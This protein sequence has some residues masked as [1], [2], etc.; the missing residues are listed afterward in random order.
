M[1]Q[2]QTVN[3]LNGIDLSVLQETILAVKE[4]PELGK[5][6]LRATNKW[7]GGTHNRTTIGDFFAAGE[8][9]THKQPFEVE[10]DEPPLLAGDDEAPNPVEYLLSSLASCVTTSLVAHA[11]VR[12]IHIEELESEVEGDIDVRGCLGLSN[13]VPRGYT[14]IR[15]TCHVKADEDNMD[16]L[17]RLAQ[18]SPVYSTLIN[19]VNMDLKVEPK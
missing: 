2:R 18:Y 8:E 4:N 17:K 5:C 10:A 1:A 11:A 3:L 19:G 15:V 12:G 9:R 7:L 14:N 6:R 16:R 13:E